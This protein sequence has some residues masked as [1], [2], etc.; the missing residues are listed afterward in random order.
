MTAKPTWPTPTAAVTASPFCSGTG[1]AASP[2]R[3]VVR[4]PPAPQPSSVA[5]GDF[6]GDG[7][8]DLA[9][10]NQG[11]NSVTVLLGDGSGGFTPMSGSP[12]PA[13][14]QPAS[15]VVGDFNGDGR[16]D[17]AIADAGGNNVTVLLGNFGY[18]RVDLFTRRNGG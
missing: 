1:T 16:A 13:G 17:L 3:P 5:V 8:L 6:N 2:R 10:A 7:R 15:L 14:T 4:L 12:F 18:D 11:G 9:I